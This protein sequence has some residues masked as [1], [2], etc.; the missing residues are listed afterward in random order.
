MR[1]PQTHRTVD[2]IT[3][4]L[5]EVVRTPG[6]SFAELARALDAP[7]SSTHGFI[8]GLL[9]RGWLYEADRRFY[10]GPAVYALTLSSGE[11]RAG[12]VTQDD[13]NELFEASSLPVFLG[14]RAGDHLI[15]V[16]GAG[17]DPVIGFHARS[18]IR[19]PLLETAG[20]KALLAELSPSERDAH[21]A[22]LGSEGR[23]AVDSFLHDLPGISSGRTAVNTRP[24]GSRLGIATVVHNQAGVAVAS[25]TLVGPISVVE[26]RVPELRKLLLG[27]AGDWSRR[28]ASPREAV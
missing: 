20:G 3:Q 25:V 22:R 13:L 11:I 15:Y 28:A 14:V 8:R 17:E 10:L 18:N 12:S 24:G 19:R 1:A 21:L 27:H 26:P 2:R 23:E 4:V 6:V 7:K 5:E 9:V 16:A